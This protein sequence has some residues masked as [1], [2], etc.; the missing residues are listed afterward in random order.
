MSVDWLESIRS[1]LQ[2]RDQFER[3]CFLKIFN[4][5]S[6]LSRECVRLRLHNEDLKQA[7]SANYITSTA[8]Q[9]NDSTENTP[10][11]GTPKVNSGIPKINSSAESQILHLGESHCLT[12][13]NQEIELKGEKFIIKSSLVKG[14][15]AFHLSEKDRINPQK[16][17]FEKRLQQNLDIYKLIFLSFGEIDCRENEGILS[18]CKKTG[19]EIQDVAESTATSYFEWTMKSLSRQREKIVYF[20]TP[21]PIAHISSNKGHLENN[22]KRLVVVKTFNT[23]LAKQCQEAGILF[24]DVYQLTSRNDGYNNNLWM[25]DSTH[26]KPEALSELIKTI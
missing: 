20:G 2:V 19:K 13:T 11:S 17:A 14:A 18:H 4:V 8:E 3:N 10:H 7:L 21:A 24:A 26:L 5:H 12:F 6:D 1:E 23:I 22:E 16:M 25:L 9:D 15:K